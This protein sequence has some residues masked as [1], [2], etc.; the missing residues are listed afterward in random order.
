MNSS[1]TV[2]HKTFDIIYTKNMNSSF[3]V[4]HKAYQ[5]DAINILRIYQ[6]L[7]DKYNNKKD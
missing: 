6:I 1:F 4:L 5:T 3:T 2:L 7:V